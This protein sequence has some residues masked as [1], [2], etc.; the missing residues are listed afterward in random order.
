MS[1]SALNGLR[2]ILITSRFVSKKRKVSCNCRHVFTPPGGWASCHTPP[3]TTTNSQKTLLLTLDN[4]WT[5][6]LCPGTVYPKHGCR[7]NLCH[8]WSQLHQCVA[9]IGWLR[10]V[11]YLF[12]LRYLCSQSLGSIRHK[13]REV[14]ASSPAGVRIRTKGCGWKVCGVTTHI[15]LTK[16]STR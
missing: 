1:A 2:T 10:M 6:L 16:L 3:Y 11:L 8:S 4:L 13:V 9:Y 14:D 12:R 7:I 5:L 15:V